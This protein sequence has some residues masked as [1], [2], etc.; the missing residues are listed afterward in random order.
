MEIGFLNINFNVLFA[1]LL[2][3]GLPFSIYRSKFRKLVYQTS[4][5]TINIKPVFLDEIKALFGNLYPG[6]RTYTRLR[7]FYRMYLTIY[8]ILFTAYYLIG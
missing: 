4:T 6:N 3:W 7:N 5:W 2:I 1:L 8:F